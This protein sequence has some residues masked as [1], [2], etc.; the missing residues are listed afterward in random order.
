MLQE[1]RVL[2]V[3][4]HLIDCHWRIVARPILQGQNEKHKSRIRSEPSISVQEH[5]SRLEIQDPYSD[6]S[7]DD[8]RHMASRIFSKVNT[9]L[10]G[11]T[12]AKFNRQLMN[13]KD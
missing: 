10:R 2:L 6:P 11:V 5:L 3:L 13:A 8:L 4:A 12:V 1:Q 7:E 9:F